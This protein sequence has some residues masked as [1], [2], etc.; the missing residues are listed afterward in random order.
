MSTA[1]NKELMRQAFE[2]LGAGDSRPFVDSLADDVR[3]TIT[4]STEWSGTY[5]GKQEVQTRLLGPLVAQFADRYT[6]RAERLIA[7]D[8]HVVVEFRGSVITTA[9]L[10]YNN[11]YC[12]V[13]RLAGGKVREIRE[14]WD[15][16]L[17]AAVLEAPAGMNEAPSRAVT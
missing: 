17:A 2:A 10:D 12:Y 1:E 8:D 14:Y 4:G 13:C 6:A 16:A 15:T 7:E 9:G 5:Y 11:T 3:W